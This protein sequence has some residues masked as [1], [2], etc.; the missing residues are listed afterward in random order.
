MSL[1]LPPGWIQLEHE[2]LGIDF[3]LHTASRVC[4]WTRPYHCPASDVSYHDGPPP[5]ELEL[6]KFLT[7]EQATEAQGR[8]EAR[9]NTAVKDEN[10]N[11]EE[12]MR[13]MVPLTGFSTFGVCEPPAD[14]PMA[15][16]PVRLP[17]HNSADTIR[18]PDELMHRSERR[19]EPVTQLHER[20]QPTTQLSHGASCPCCLGGQ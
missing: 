6:V 11:T 15:G 19:S 16:Q 5:E 12:H 2:Q 9:E 10:T 14:A 17:I 18:S 13:D 3:Y 20:M 7:T 1:D 8:A 4:A